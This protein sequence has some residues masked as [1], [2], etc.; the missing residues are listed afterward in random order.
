MIKPEL[1]SKLSSIADFTCKGGDKI[2]LSNNE[3]GY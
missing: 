3:A 2:R 1:K